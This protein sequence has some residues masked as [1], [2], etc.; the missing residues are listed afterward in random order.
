MAKRE[1][2]AT[3][4]S[5]VSGSGNGGGANLRG[6]TISLVCCSNLSLDHG[7]PFFFQD[8][9]AV[10]FFET[11][12]NWRESDSGAETVGTVVPKIGKVLSQIGEP[13]S[14]ALVNGYS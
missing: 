10:G 11:Q 14:Y 1:I 8:H 4:T 2:P 9:K 13:G 5:R 12:A 6:S 7:T 3:R